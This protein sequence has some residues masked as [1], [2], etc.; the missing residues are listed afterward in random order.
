MST[1]VS[2][3]SER[4]LRVLQI[5]HSPQRRGAEVFAHQLSGAMRER[6]CQVRTAYLYPAAGPGSL[7][8]I[9]GDVVLASRQKRLVETSL[10]LD[11]CLL[12]RTVGVL[13][14][15]DPDVVQANGGRTVKYGAA[16][17]FVLRARW[18][19][20]GRNIGDPEV[21]VRGPRRRLLYR[22]VIMPRMDGLVGV[23]RTTLER[24]IRFYAVTVPTTYLPRAVDEAKLIPSRGFTEV[25]NE[26]ATPDDAPVLVFVGTLSREKRLDWLLRTLPHVRR[27]LPSVVLWLVGDGHKRRELEKY[28]R[29]LGVSDSVRFLGVQSS[30]ADFLSAADLLVLTSDTEGTP[31][32]ILEA[33]LLEVPAVA[34]RVGGVP[35]CLVDGETGLLIDPSDERAFAEAVVTLLSDDRRRARM[36]ENAAKRVRSQFLLDAIAPAY[37]DFYRSVLNAR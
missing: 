22:H 36:G 33:G 3:E 12:R 18:A 30:V 27:E 26:L 2:A 15:V 35:E 8:L 32:V 23:S 31:G 17:K 4:P 7:P 29:R 6:G 14:R 16:A 21:W 13:R 9:D 19:L 37:L 11:P 5:V 10:G 28:A 24:A 20:I 1:A 34:T 25:R